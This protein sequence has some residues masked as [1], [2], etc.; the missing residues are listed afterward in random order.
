[1]TIVLQVVVQRLR[2]LWDWL[3]TPT[4]VKLFRYSVVSVI[5]VGISQLAL[6]ITFGILQ[7]WSAVWCNIFAAVIATPPSYY[8][9]RR[10]AWGKSGKSHLW[11]EIVPF[12]VLAFTG[13]AVSVVAVH[14]AEVWSKD[15]TSSHLA[16]SIIVNAAS[17]FAYGVV[18][19]AKFLIFNRYMFI[20][21]HHGAH[22]REA[23]QA[24]EPEVPAGMSGVDEG[25]DGLAVVAD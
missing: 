19:V 22:G 11:R 13:L 7:L 6:F 23:A 3:H 4:G 5:S 24:P 18:W 20:E 16:Q 12:W 8:L 17:A 25:D 15:F 9:N 2:Q 1:M 10:W 21:H 14:L